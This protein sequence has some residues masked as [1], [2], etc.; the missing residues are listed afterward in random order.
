V[1]VLAER[2]RKTRDADED[3]H[4]LPRRGERRIGTLV[5]ALRKSDRTGATS[6]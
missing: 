1:V 6:G 4:E 3:V 2:R 5:A